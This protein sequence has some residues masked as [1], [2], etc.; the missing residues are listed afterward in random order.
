MLLNAVFVMG[1]VLANGFFVAAEFATV[2]TFS[3]VLM[4]GAAPP[5][6]AAAIL[7][8]WAATNQS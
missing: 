7:F 4:R 1:L 5:S 2:S 8:R 3:A 6:A